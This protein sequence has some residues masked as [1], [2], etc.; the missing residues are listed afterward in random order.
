[1]RGYPIGKDLDLH[2]SWEFPLWPVLAHVF[3]LFA[4]S[5]S[6]HGKS[7]QVLQ[8]GLIPGPGLGERHCLTLG[9]TVEAS[10]VPRAHRVILGVS[11]G[12]EV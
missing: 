11:R 4:V 5:P 6:Q 2:I 3:P 10:H 8:H 7:Y 9:Q 12:G 1:M